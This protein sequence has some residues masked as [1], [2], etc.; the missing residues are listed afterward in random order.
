[1][2]LRATLAMAAALAACRTPERAPAGVEPAPAPP[3]APP[4]PAPTTHSDAAPAPPEPSDSA[5]APAAPR[6]ASALE[7]PSLLACGV[8]EPTSTYRA[9]LRREKLDGVYVTRRIPGAKEKACA[10]PTPEILTLARSTVEQAAANAPLEISL[11]CG[12]AAG[13]FLEATFAP[14]KTFRAG[15][16]V[17]HCNPE[18]DS[19]CEHEVVAIWQL[20]VIGAPRLVPGAYAVAEPLDVD[21]DGELEGLAS[22]AR[23]T[24]VWFSDGASVTGNAAGAW[25]P[26][27]KNLALVQGGSEEGFVVSQARAFTVSRRGFTERPELVQ[28]AWESTYAARCPRE[29][30][31][32]VPPGSGGGAAGK[33][34]EAARPCPPISDDNRRAATEPIL[35]AIVTEAKETGRQVT[36]GPPHF[37]W[38]CE[39]P[40]LAVLVTYCTG[41]EAL[42]CA[43]EHGTWRQELWIRSPRGMTRATRVDSSSL[44][45]E[46]EVHSTQRLVTHADLDGDGALDPIF[47]TREQ[48]I[49]AMQELLS[50]HA[51]AR[52]KV[53]AF[54]SSAVNTA[55]ETSVFAIRLP[56]APRD[57]VALSHR[58]VVPSAQ[59]EP[60]LAGHG[61]T[62]WELGPRNLVRHRGPGIALAKRELAKHRKEP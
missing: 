12:T 15:A 44:Y 43:D 57:L 48:E 19:E 25:L 11:G 14:K 50:Y 2:L 46:W 7:P 40:R 35:A 38:G 16:P 59:G 60:A 36:D 22:G 49:G 39:Q 9:T 29:P 30:F 17:P 1:M 56:G 37:S 24:T 8:G 21:G 54:A 41:Y 53:M 18:Q 55:L 6:D 52:G 20:P 31:A 27:G 58:Q 4:A 13:W 42:A 10:E 28:K 45:L 34:P 23:G 47:E 51:V 32:P 26:V 5:P 33:A 62:V 61:L 3:A